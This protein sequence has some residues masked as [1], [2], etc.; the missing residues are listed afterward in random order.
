MSPGV[1]EG[2]AQQHDQEAKTGSQ[3]HGR[4]EQELIHDKNT[5]K[6][7]KYVLVDICFGFRIHLFRTHSAL[8]FPTSN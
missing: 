4:D 8:R 6:F 7:L 5:K 1:P 3:A 2:A